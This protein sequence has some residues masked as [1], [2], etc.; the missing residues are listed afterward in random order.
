MTTSERRSLKRA[1]LRLLTR[2]TECETSP[3][4]SHKMSGEAEV[5]AV[6]DISAV[7]DIAYKMDSLRDNCPLS[8]GKGGGEGVTGEE[9]VPQWEITPGW[10]R[11]RLGNYRAY[12]TCCY[13]RLAT[14][15]VVSLFVF[16]SF[17]VNTSRLVFLNNIFPLNLARENIAVNCPI[18]VR[19]NGV[20][21]SAA[22]CEEKTGLGSETSAALAS[23]TGLPARIGYARRS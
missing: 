14:G 16:H 13:Y 18:F 11:L 12:Y 7:S 17:F 2:L 5:E 8:W 4:V 1:S 6:S 3:W 20:I 19:T 9:V 15:N 10:Y 23:K 21:I 22:H